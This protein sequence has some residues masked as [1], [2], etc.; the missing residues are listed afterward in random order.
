M[1]KRSNDGA[2]GVSQRSANS[3]Q[4]AGLKKN[5]PG[6]VKTRGSFGGVAQSKHGVP[7]VKKYETISGRKDSSM[8][9]I[10]GKS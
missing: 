7:L 4:P 10:N 8:Q 9:S 2:A 1:K 6:F 3:A 5:G